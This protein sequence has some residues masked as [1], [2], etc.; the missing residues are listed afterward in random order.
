MPNANDGEGVMSGV[1]LLYADSTSVGGHDLAVEF[2]DPTTDHC[3]GGGRDNGFNEEDRNE[4]DHSYPCKMSADKPTA[5]SDHPARHD[6][7]LVIEKGYRRDE[8]RV[9]PLNQADDFCKSISKMS[10][11]VWSKRSDKSPAMKIVSD[12]KSLL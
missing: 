9:Q 5:N 12:W 8:S 7:G 6:D 11:N 1:A 2:G 10:E 3:M 4:D